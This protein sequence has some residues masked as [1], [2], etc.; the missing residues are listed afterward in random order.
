MDIAFYRLYKD[1]SPQVRPFLPPDQAPYVLF[2]TIKCNLY[3][4]E[5]PNAELW[6]LLIEAARFQLNTYGI[7][8]FRIDIGQQRTAGHPYSRT[9]KIIGRAAEQQ[10]H[11]RDREVDSET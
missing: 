6:E 9:G 10:I 8:G 5:E 11:Y 4:G 2:D 1:F 3:P 7:D